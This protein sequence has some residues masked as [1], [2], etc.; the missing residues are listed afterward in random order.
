MPVNSCSS[1]Y[2][3]IEHHVLPPTASKLKHAQL[4]IHENPTTVKAMEAFGLFVSASMF[5]TLP[6]AFAALGLGAAI[7][8]GVSGALA[9]ATSSVAYAALDIAAPPY[10]NMKHH[11]FTPGRCEGGRLYYQGDVPILSLDADHPFLARKAHGYL[12]GNALNRG[13]SRL[14][15]AMHTLAR[16][17]RASEVWGAIEFVKKSMPKEYLTEM[18]GLVEGYREWAK[19]HP[20]SRPKAITLDDLILLHLLPD[21]THYKPPT[22]DPAQRPKVSSNNPSVACTVV[23]DRDEKGE[24]LFAR[25]MD[26]PSMGVGGTYSLIINRK[27][28]NGLST[29]EVGIPGMIGT[30][31]G[32]NAKGL[33]LAMNVCTGRTFRPLGMPAAL[34]NRKCLENCSTLSHVDAFVKRNQPLGPYHLTVADKRSAT[35]YH[36]YQSNSEHELVKR[37]WTKVDPLVVL[38]FRYPTPTSATHSMEYSTDRE[39]TLRSWFQQAKQERCSKADTVGRSLSLPYVNNWET[40]HAVVMKGDKMDV[41][42]NNAYA[43]KYPRHAVST[44]ELFSPVLGG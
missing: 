19:M 42:F 2:R 9:L 26:W 15:F 33:K 32:M 44:Q 4:W 3:V 43:A 10:H 36:F 31:T 38:N 41:A 21:S 11:A 25:N 23:I 13:F 40:T 27:R 28:K 34:F 1:N 16:A 37:K 18:E 20:A 22:L 29:V 6:Y 24:L 12:L 35:A 14:D 5:V 8:W 17:P 7:V 39:K 30:L